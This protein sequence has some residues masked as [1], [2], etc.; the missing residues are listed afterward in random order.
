MARVTLIRHGKAET[1]KAGVQDF[2]RSLISRGQ[3]KASAVGAFLA[4]HRMLPQLVLEILQPLL[5]HWNLGKS[6]ARDFAI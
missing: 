6:E 2:D 1:S 3:I 5:N 4:T